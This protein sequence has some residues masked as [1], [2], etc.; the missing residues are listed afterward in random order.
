[1]EALTPLQRSFLLLCTDDYTGLENALRDVQ[2]AYP[3]ADSTQARALTL[4]L[5]KELL[6]AGYIQAGDLPG[7]GEQWKPWALNVDEIVERIDREWEKLGKEREDL[8]DIVWFVST[9]EGDRALAEDKDRNVLN[10]S[11][12]NGFDKV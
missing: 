1:M 2:E 8:V 12:N 11:E 6:Q 7:V 4:K 9:V 10:E 3:S 5:I